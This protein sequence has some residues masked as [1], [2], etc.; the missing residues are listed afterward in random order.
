LNRRTLIAIHS[1]FHHLLFRGRVAIRETL[2]GPRANIRARVNRL[3]YA[4][5]VVLQDVYGVRFILEPW[6]AAARGERV[7][8]A[9][10][11][12]E[13]SALRRLI[14]EGDTVFDLGA[15]VGLHAALFSKWVGSAGR[16]L[17]FEPV[18]ETAWQLR[19]TLAL[20]RCANVEVYELAILDRA[21]HAEMNTFGPRHAAW[22][23]FGRP[24]FGDVTANDVITVPIQ[25]LDT[26]CNDERIDHIDFLKIDVE[27]F[28][29]SVI[30]GAKEL[31]TSN[32]I[33]SLS[34]EISQIPL[35]GS[36][37]KPKEIF[38][39]LRACGYAAYRYDP[40]TQGFVGPILD[41]DA[42]YENFYA[43]RKDLRREQGR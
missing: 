18:P 11:R 40:A 28:E 8:G 21:G 27:G 41:S 7:S 1:R 33:G 3:S 30:Q 2:R 6:D 12:D 35:E 14:S 22:N 37:V 4:K 34:F 39:A 16:V 25:D 20:N 5:P 9:F 19:E 24:K 38:D 42:F 23:T 32:R 36:G 31:L 26:F 15:N 10:Y 17:A 43:S 29:R 13:F